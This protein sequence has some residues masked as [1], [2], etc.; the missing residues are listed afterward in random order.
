MI[1]KYLRRIFWILGCCEIFILVEAYLI[2]C[3]SDTLGNEYYIWEVWIISAESRNM[4]ERVFLILF[5]WSAVPAFLQATEVCLNSCFLELLQTVQGNGICS[6]NSLKGTFICSDILEKD[7]VNFPFCT[8]NKVPLFSKV[9]ILVFLT[10]IG[11]H[12]PCIAVKISSLL[13]TWSQLCSVCENVFS[14]ARPGRQK[15]RLC[16]EKHLCRLPNTQE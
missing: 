7:Q 2:I 4:W 9:C 16:M 12:H 3:C 1:G 8:G 14:F 11:Q 6:W 10:G 13:I 15:M 5:F